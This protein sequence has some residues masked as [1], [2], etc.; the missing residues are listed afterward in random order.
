M[1]GGFPFGSGYFGDAPILVG[2]VPVPPVLVDGLFVVD[3]TG[4][5]GSESVRGRSGLMNAMGRSGSAAVIGRS[6]SVS[7]RGRSARA[8]GVRASRPTAVQDES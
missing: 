1:Y 8:S 3:L 5:G 2:V 7:V 6:L 4:R